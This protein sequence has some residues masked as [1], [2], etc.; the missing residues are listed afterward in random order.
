M[1]L[2][3]IALLLLVAG[4]AKVGWLRD[5]TAGLAGVAAEPGGAAAA[6][7]AAADVVRAA[8]RGDA[9][10]LVFTRRCRQFRDPGLPDGLNVLGTT[11]SPAANGLDRS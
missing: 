5:G 11:L 10:V 9:D 2:I 7:A 3:A 6:T 1:A 8:D 4:G